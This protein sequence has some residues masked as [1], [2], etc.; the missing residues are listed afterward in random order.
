M[1]THIYFCLSCL[2]LSCQSP[3]TLTIENHGHRGCRGLMPENSIPAFLK[4][5]D[6]GVDYIEIDIVVNHQG[7][8]IISHEP[9]FNASFSTDA[10]G[11]P[12]T[13]ELS[14]SLNIYKMDL[15]E[16]Q[17]YDVGIRSNPKYPE[18]VST[19]AHK[20][21]LRE[22]VHAVKKYCQE[23][24]ITVPRWNI[25]AKFD[26]RYPAYFPQR[27]S[28]AKQVIAEIHTLDLASDCIIQCFDPELLNV[29]HQY[30]N[31]L[32]YG[33]LVDNYITPES[34]LKEL[35]FKP[36]GYMPNHQLLDQSTMD[37]CR[38]QNIQVLV[39]TVNSDQDMQRMMNLKVD[40]IISD[41]P[42][43][44]QKKLEF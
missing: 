34:N 14:Q 33:L 17:S 38:S 7:E 32:K 25:E 29:F 42:D 12:V 35:S 20:P 36:F 3:M 9:F 30:D 5:V 27:E 39:W 22:A 21:T 11:N 10:Q 43:R 15:K 19:P 44:L 13:E 4:A 37:Y 41:Y 31:T 28:Y 8:V 1:K 24:K 16:I 18:Q 2:L 6:I 26:A 40:G 23:S